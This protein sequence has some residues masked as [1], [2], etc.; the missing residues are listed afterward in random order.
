[1]REVSIHGRVIDTRRASSGWTVQ[2]DETRSCWVWRAWG[3]TGSR[4]GA[5]TTEHHAVTLAR[6]TQEELF[7]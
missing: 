1:M 3:I 5:A 2:F 4:S 6:R 7:R